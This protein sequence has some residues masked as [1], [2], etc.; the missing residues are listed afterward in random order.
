MPV[1]VNCQ[2]LRP[3]DRTAIGLFLESVRDL[4]SHVQTLILTDTRTPYDTDSEAFPA[5]NAFAFRESLVSLKI[6]GKY[7]LRY[8]PG[9]LDFTAEIPYALKPVVTA[10]K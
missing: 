9:F 3:Q 7:P 10:L 6:Y 4:A 1:E 8:D 5:H 2:Y